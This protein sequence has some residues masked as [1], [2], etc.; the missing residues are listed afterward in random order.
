MNRNMR[1]IEPTDEELR[2]A[3]DSLSAWQTAAQFIGSVEKLGQRVPTKKLWGNRYKPL[4]EA[5]TLAKFC[6][7]RRVKA[8]RMGEDPP[9]AWLRFEDDQDEQV[10]ITEVQEP[11][12]KRGDEYKQAGVAPAIFVADSQLSERAKL[13]S[14][15][16]QK[17]IDAKNGKYD[18]KPH[19]LVYLNIP[20]GRAEHQV[21][22]AIADMRLKHA[23]SFR[24]LHVVTD[25][26][27]L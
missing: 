21:Q 6:Q 9:D 3:L 23:D 8:V 24:E 2:R 4:R 1:T 16:L 18:F 11:N 13:V 15:E 20:Y 26:K 7:H 25:T 5:M 12:R 14:S 17:A 27:L 22:A 10:E 19:L